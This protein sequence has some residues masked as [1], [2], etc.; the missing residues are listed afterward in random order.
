M[1]PVNKDQTNVDI[2]EI[3]GW[4][5]AILSVAGI[6]ITIFQQINNCPCSQQEQSHPNFLGVCVIYYIHQVI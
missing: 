2:C 3:L 4:T 5:S 1:A 6:A